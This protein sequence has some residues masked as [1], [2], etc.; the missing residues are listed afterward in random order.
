MD[1]LE[2]AKHARCVWEE[3]PHLGHLYGCLTLSCPNGLL[4]LEEAKVI[5]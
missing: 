2:Y 4:G 1:P 3:I 5:K